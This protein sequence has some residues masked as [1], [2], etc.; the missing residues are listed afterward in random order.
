M[1]FAS[2]AQWRHLFAQQSRGEVPRGTA[3]EMAAAS[4]PFH[5]LPAYAGEDPIERAMMQSQ[6]PDPRVWR[7]KARHPRKLDRLERFPV[8]YDPAH[9]GF[10]PVIDSGQRRLLKPLRTGTRAR[11]GQEPAFDVPGNLGVTP[12]P[13]PPVSQVVRESELAK[14]R[15]LL[16]SYLSE[17]DAYARAL[18][19]RQ[20]EIER[21]DRQRS[22]QAPSSAPPRWLPL[23]V[24][25]ALGATLL[26]AFGRHAR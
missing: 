2:Q 12:G 26:V 1:P 9:H 16:D 21:E 15:E 3:E 4:P 19:D 5:S 23:V 7:P 10:V 22:A 25:G 13:V 8:R 20:T 24:A 11:V 17:P 18:A 14:A 6:A